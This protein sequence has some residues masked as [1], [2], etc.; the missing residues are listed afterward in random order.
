M[1][2]A[3]HA[4][5]R[6]SQQAVGVRGEIDGIIESVTRRRSVSEVLQ[7]YFLSAACQIICKVVAAA[8]CWPKVIA[9]S[10]SILDILGLKEILG[11]VDLV[12]AS[13]VQHVGQLQDGEGDDDHGEEDAQP[14][15]V[16]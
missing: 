11:D 15:M 4:I 3:V 12:G 5:W 13:K 7:L 6:D 14:G 9:S 8:Y 16:G 10:Q 2:V 1:D